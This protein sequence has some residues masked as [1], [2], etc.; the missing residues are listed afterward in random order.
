M[1]EGSQRVRWCKDS[2]AWKYASIRPQMD[3]VLFKVFS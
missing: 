1:E 3:L 2:L